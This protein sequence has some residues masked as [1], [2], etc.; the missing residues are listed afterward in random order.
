MHPLDQGS[1]GKLRVDHRGQ[2]FGVE[3]L[4]MDGRMQDSEHQLHFARPTRVTC[5]RDLPRDPKDLA[6]D[7]DNNDIDYDA[8]HHNHDRHNHQ[9]GHLAETTTT[10]TTTPS[11]P[12]TPIPYGHY[13][14]TNTTYEKVASATEGADAAA[15]CAGPNLKTSAYFLHL[16]VTG[17]TAIYLSGTGGPGL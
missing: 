2:R 15:A 14:W 16:T 12:S 10:T 9:D 4:E 13:Y 11:A 8:N 1:A 5:H 7:A 17:S 3:I 6:A